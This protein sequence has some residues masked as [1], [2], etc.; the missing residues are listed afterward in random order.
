[1]VTWWC[2]GRGGLKVMPQW[3]GFEGGG[4]MVVKNEGC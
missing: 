1:M 3:K 4:L 2:I